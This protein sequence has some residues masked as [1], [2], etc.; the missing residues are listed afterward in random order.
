M[1]PSGTRHLLVGEQED[2]LSAG[3]KVVAG[4]LPV[5]GILLVVVVVAGIL[6]VV[7][8]SLVAGEPAVVGRPFDVQ[9]GNV[10]K[11]ILSTFI[12]RP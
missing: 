5:A 3:Y 6:V 8:D 12:R 1:K 2:N 9:E 4:T 7:V 11:T 10:L